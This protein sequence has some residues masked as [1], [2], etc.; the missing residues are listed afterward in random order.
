MGGSLEINV[1]SG[2]AILLVINNGGRGLGRD[3]LKL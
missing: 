2:Y 1:I 3:G